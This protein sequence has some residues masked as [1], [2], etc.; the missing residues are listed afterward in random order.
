VQNFQIIIIGG[1]L[2]GLTAAIHLASKGMEVV[3]I[4]KEQYPHHKVCGEYLSQEVMPYLES[5][6]IDIASL[7]PTIIKRM[8]YSSINGKT[9]HCDLDMG[10]IGVSRYS[11]DQLLF[12]KAKSSD[13]QIINAQ[14]TE[15]EYSN[16]TFKVST[17]EGEIITSEFVLGAFG[18]R[19][20]LDKKLNR[21]FIQ[22]KSRWLAVKAHYKMKSGIFPDDLVAL[23]NFDGGYC[24]LSMTE[25]GNVNACY[26]ATYTSFKNHK[27]TEQYRKKILMK[28]PHLKEFFENAE[29]V[30]KKDLSIAQVSFDSKTLVDNHIIMLGDSAG[31]IHPLC[32]NGMAMAIHSAK[33]A[34]EEI[35]KFYRVKDITRSDLENSYIKIWNQKFNTRLKVGRML[36]KILLNKPLNN[37][38][39][40]LINRFP[41]LLPHIIKR[42]HGKQI[43][44]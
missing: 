33:I 5:L 25:L 16:G 29:I 7:K 15:I 34:S 23:H 30:F 19:S 8:K 6:E 21:K 31:L 2:A 24:G 39:Q 14:A 17:S 44:V 18:K 13:C 42:T 22:E 3:L 43:H 9:I 37:I 11:L 36:Q 4:E 12:E 28:N 38:S 32:G 26:L 20:N 1:G 27:S 10:G 40:N 35:L 41:Q